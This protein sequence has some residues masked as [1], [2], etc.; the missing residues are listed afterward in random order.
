[1]QNT[2]NVRSKGNAGDKTHC[3]RSARG[4]YYVEGEKPGPL[5]EPEQKASGSSPQSSYR[6][7][8]VIVWATQVK[9][10]IPTR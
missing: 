8:W 4:Q 3:V 7:Y 1:M 6:V 10:E 5:K 9:V 2:R